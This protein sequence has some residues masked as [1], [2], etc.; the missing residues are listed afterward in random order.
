M[1]KI[2]KDE[3]EDEDGRRFTVYGFDVVLP[4]SI[5]AVKSYPDIFFDKATAEKFIDELNGCDIEDKQ[6]PEIVDDT[7]CLLYSD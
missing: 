2:R 4:D 3:I 5:E 1:Y 7:I 6:I